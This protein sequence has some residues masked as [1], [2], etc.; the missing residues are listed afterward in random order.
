MAFPLKAQKTYPDK[1]DRKG[2]RDGPRERDD[3]GPDNDGCAEGEAMQPADD[4]KAG[5]KA[6]GPPAGFP[7][8]HQPPG[9][10]KPGKSQFALKR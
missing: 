7:P 10:A 4:A 8:K 3:R 1:A 5:P 6:K 2:Y 9:G